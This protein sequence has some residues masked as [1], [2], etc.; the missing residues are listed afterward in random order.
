MIHSRKLWLESMLRIADPVLEALS[1]RKLKELMPVDSPLV[2]RE[3][4]AHLEALGRLLAG[5][6]PWLERKQDGEEEVLRNKYAAMARQAI[7]AGT[8]RN[9]PDFMNFTEGGQPLVDAAFLSHA[10]VRAPQELY[11]QLEPRVKQQLIECLKKTRRIKAVPSNWLLFSAMVEAALYMMGEEDFDVMRVDYA[12]KQHEHWYLGDGTYGDGPNFHWDYYNSFVIQ[13]MLIDIHR[14]FKGMY[15]DW[16]S[17]YEFVLPRAQR[18]GALLERMISPEGTFP[19][20]GRS[21]AYRFGAFQLLSQLALME[22]L[23]E[24]LNC[25]SVR[26]ALTAVLQR[27]IAGEGTF[28][29]NGWLQIGFYGNQPDIAEGYISTGSLYLCSTFFLP[30]GLSSDQPFWAMPD[31][32]WTQKR[33]WSGQSFSLDHSVF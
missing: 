33:A 6:A 20:V 24:K 26:C 18:Y 17:A 15:P 9:S 8:D 12:L 11:G 27:A 2:G 30:L 4:Y 5:I 23:P 7:D 28:D 25:A 10:I 22:T 19:P 16:D 29:E 31:E 14:T 21:L 3:T 1:N 13:P 32:P